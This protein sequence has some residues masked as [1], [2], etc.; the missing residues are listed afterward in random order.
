M[1][2]CGSCLDPKSSRAS[3]G[4][5]P[6]PPAEPQRVQQL[7]AKAEPPFRPAG[8][9]VHYPTAAGGTTPAAAAGSYAAPMDNPSLGHLGSIAPEYYRKV[10]VAETRV[11]TFLLDYIEARKLPI[12]GLLINGSYT[13]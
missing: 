10:P 4:S 12:D 13:Q 6:P 2:V 8:F 5:R 7:E 1:G 11:L 3:A 9:S